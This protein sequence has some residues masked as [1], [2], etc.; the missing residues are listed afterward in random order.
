MYAAF[1]NSPVNLTDPLGLA[2]IERGD[3]R[4]VQEEVAR[5]RQEALQRLLT[6]AEEYLLAHQ[7]KSEEQIRAGLARHLKREGFA[8]AMHEAH[9]LTTALLGPG[10]CDGSRHVICHFKG[11]GRVARAMEFVLVN[12]TMLAMGE[13][14]AVELVAAGPSYAAMLETIQ[15]EATFGRALA[16]ARGGV[17]TFRVQG[18]VLPNASKLR[19]VVDEGGGLSIAGDDMLFVNVN[20]EARAVEFLAQRGEGASL[21]RFE[22]RPEFVEKLQ[23]SAVRQELGRLNPNL[24]QRVDVT[25]APDQFGIPANMFDELLENVVPGSVRVTTP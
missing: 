22:L 10:Q 21:V 1:G 5:E 7:G 12:A 19:F 14:V 24:P 3:V 25:V 2:P 15:A 23:A 13:L 20:Q 4:Y 8:G 18:G 6:S 17:A 11:T 16:A 9:N